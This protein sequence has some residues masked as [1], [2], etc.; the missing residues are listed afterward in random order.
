M[1]TRDVRGDQ[2]MPGNK[3]G[4]SSDSFKNCTDVCDFV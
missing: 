4:V 1:T 2:G 3:G